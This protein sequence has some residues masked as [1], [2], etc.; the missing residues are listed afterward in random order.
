MTHKP[1]KGHGS[2]SLLF[3]N[4]IGPISNSHRSNKFNRP[5]A[6]IKS[7]RFALLPK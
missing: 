1:E 7:L 3:F 4:A 2:K 5:F 6:A